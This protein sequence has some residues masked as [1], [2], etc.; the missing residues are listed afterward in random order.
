MSDEYRMTEGQMAGLGADVG[1]DDPL[2]DVPDAGDDSVPL[3]PPDP[4]DF[5]TKGITSAGAAGMSTFNDDDNRTFFERT[6]DVFEEAGVDPPML[7]DGG[8]EGETPLPRR[9]VRIYESS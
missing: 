7:G 1:P 9:R 6:V 5:S 2:P 4:V 3:T 8:S